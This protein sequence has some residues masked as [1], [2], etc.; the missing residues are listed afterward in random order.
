MPIL[1]QSANPQ[2]ILPQYR[3]IH[4]D[5]CTLIFWNKS[6]W[7]MAT[8]LS[9]GRFHS[10]ILDNICQS[11][12]NPLTHDHPANPPMQCQSRLYLTILVKQPLHNQAK[13][14][15]HQSTM[16][17]QRPTR[18][19]YIWTNVVIPWQSTNPSLIYQSNPNPSPIHYIRYKSTAANQSPI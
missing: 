10:S 16:P 18:G 2:P 4:L 11:T 19:Q 15:W 14:N 6:L 17:I 8:S 7:G 3:P 12:A 5:N 9:R 13:L 1:Y